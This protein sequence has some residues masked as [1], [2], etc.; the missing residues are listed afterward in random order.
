MLDSMIVGQETI[1]RSIVLNMDTGVASRQIEDG[2]LTS[3]IILH[4]L[5]VLLGNAVFEVHL[6]SLILGLICIPY[7]VYSYVCIL[8]YSILNLN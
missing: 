4:H 6:I 8:L 2:D 1:P 5:S 7:P 3:S